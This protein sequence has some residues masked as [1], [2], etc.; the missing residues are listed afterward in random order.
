MQILD[1]TAVAAHF[2]EQIKL[3][4]EELK[5]SGGKTPHLAVIMVGD[6]PASAAYV[7][8][9][10]KT[11]KELGFDSTHLHFDVDISEKHLLD[12]VRRLNEDDSVDGILVQLP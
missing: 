12:Q 1:G 2:K 11:C 3:Q 7:G 8:S 9:K 10:V 6:S 4:V 5:A